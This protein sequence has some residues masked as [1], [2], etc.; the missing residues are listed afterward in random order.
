V[1]F[2]PRLKLMMVRRAKADP[3]PDGRIP[4]VWDLF[5]VA[6][7]EGGAFVG[8][9]LTDKATKK[10]VLTE[11][12]VATDDAREPNGEEIRHYT[13]VILAYPRGRMKITEADFRDGILPSP[14]GGVLPP[15]PVPKKPDVIDKNAAILTVDFDKPLRRS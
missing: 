4:A 10:D 3:G 6:G 8:M 7:E 15:P 11:V 5:I 12:R 9:F 14:G 2:Y 1:I 13:R